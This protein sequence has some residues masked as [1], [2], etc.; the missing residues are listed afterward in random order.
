[1]CVCCVY[2]HVCAQDQG[3]LSSSVHHFHILILF[4]RVCVVYVCV[5]NVCVYVCVC[6]GAVLAWRCNRS[7]WRAHTQTH[8]IVNC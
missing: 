7:G 4:E 3:A 5:C 8:T 2:T 6:L 1:M